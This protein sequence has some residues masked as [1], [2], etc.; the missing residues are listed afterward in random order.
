[1]CPS[2]SLDVELLLSMLLYDFCF[3]GIPRDN[4]RGRTCIGYFS[5]LVIRVGPD[6]YR[7]LTHSGS[8]QGETSYLLTP[9]SHYG[10]VLVFSRGS[11]RDSHQDKIFIG[12]FLLYPSGQD[13]YRLLTHSSGRQVEDP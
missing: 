3:S 8:C 7:L 1:M 4:R 2:F 9:G 12:Y 6:P 13:S 10:R 11:S 5:F